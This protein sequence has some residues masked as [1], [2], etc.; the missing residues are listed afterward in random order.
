MMAEGIV[1]LLEAVEVDQQ[2]REAH[3]FAMRSQDGLLQA[4]VKQRAIGRS[5]NE[6]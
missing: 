3:A 5:V 1:D 2:Q 6:S 4:I